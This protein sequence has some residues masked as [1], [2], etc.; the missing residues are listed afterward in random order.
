MARAESKIVMGYLPIEARHHAAILSLVTPATSAVRLLDPFAGEGEFLEAVAK[1]WN[2]T[3]YANELDGERAAKCIERFGPTQAV[4]CDV[5]RLLASNEAFGIVWANPP[6]DHDKVAKNN[7]RI[8]FSYLRHAWKWAQDGAIVLW[9][10]YN[11]HITEDAAAFLSKHS[12]RVDVWALPG[13]HLGEYDQVVL[14][15]IKGTPSDSEHLYTQIMANKAA[16]RPLTVQAEPVY[17]APTPPDPDRRFVFAPDMVDEEQGLRLVQAQGAWKSN[18]FQALLEVP[19]PPEQIEPIVPP[20][21]GHLALVLAAG[22]AD[23]AVINTEMHGRVAL[24]GKTT[25]VEEVARVET[26]ISPNDPEQKITRTTLTLLAANGDLVQMVGD[27]DLLAFITENKKALAAYLNGKFKPMYQFDFNGL[28]RWLDRIRLKGK[29]ELYTAQKHVIGAVTRGLQ[30]R[31]GV[32]LVGAMGTGKTAMGGSVAVSVGAGV[33]E[34]L[35]QDVPDDNVM[36]IVAPPHL[37]D[38]WERELCSISTQVYVERIESHGDQKAFESL[39]QFM[40]RAA[41]MGSGIAKIGLIRR[42]TTKLGAAREPAVFWKWRYKALWKRG[43]DTPDGYEPHERIHKERVPL[44][45]HCGAV[46]TQEAKIGAKYATDAWLRAGKRTCTL[47]FGAL[48]QEARADGAKPKPGQK[49]ATSNPRYRLDQYLKRMYPNRVYLLV[50]D[51]AHEAQHG[52]TGNGEAFIRMAGIAKKTLAMTGTPFNGRASSLFNLEYA[53]NPRV[54]ERYAWGG[55]E[56]LARKTAGSLWRVVASG[57]SRQR[58]RAESRW[59]AQMGV[60]ERVLEERP[61]YDRD[62]GAYTGT[63]TYE[64]P[65]E[66]APGISPL[67]VAELLDHAVYFS[68]QDL[69]KWLPSYEEIALAVP[70]DTDTGSKYESTRE[71]LKKYLID[72]RWEGDTTF[73]GAYLQWAMNWPDAAFRPCDVI[74]NLKHPI[75]GAKLSSTV[76]RLRSYGEDRIYPKEQQLIDLVRNELADNRPVVIFVRQTD[77]RDIQ[78]R[79]A[80]LIRRHVPLAKPY[81][82][83]NTVAAD[84]RER[85]IEQEVAKGTNVIFA[86]PELVKTGLDLVFSPTLVFYEI[87]FNLSTMMQ[88]AGRSLRLNQTHANCRTYYLYYEETMGETAV[89]LMSRKQRAAKL[90][91]GDIGLTGLDALTEG[92]A[93]LEEA[94]MAAIG[95]E[96]TLVDPGELFKVSATQSEIDAEDAA[97]WN[98]EGISVEPELELLPLLTVPQS[99]TIKAAEPLLLLPVTTQAEPGGSGKRGRLVK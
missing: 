1:A 77:T 86:N 62:T 27:D 14:V 90:L 81:I 15:A 94:L 49:Y 28:R 26:E 85:V 33:V 41:L 93:G 12:T 3:P 99:E 7:K 43:T 69:G 10:V 31:D 55:S 29:H 32:L 25:H 52:D 72:R 18:G 64:R 42:D 71:S 45:P 23:G 47:C 63:N 4:R 83:K 76:A 39:K 92:E 19:R 22:V 13:K 54:R 89:Y 11:Q 17:H 16:P 61:A 78:P 38:K 30:G 40:N 24:R 36:L 53:L 87:T 48:W 46:V 84:R 79:L 20:R 35:K 98:S 97:Y 6:Y 57:D 68:L 96:E 80:D 44:C 95:K 21:P 70:M 82:L 56:R 5:E 67:L 75:T 8:E 65:Y 37:I 34:A 51:E 2:V 9:A 58:G 91:N 88:A 60:R 66:E 59:V 50:W 74:H 73:R